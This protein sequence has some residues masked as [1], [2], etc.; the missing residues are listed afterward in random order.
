[1][2]RIDEHLDATRSPRDFDP[3]CPPAGY[4]MPFALLSGEHDPHCG[5]PQ[6]EFFAYHRKNSGKPNCNKNFYKA[7]RR[8]ANQRSQAF[9]AQLSS[10]P[11]LR[12]AERLFLRAMTEFD[13]L[14]RGGPPYRA[15]LVERLF[16][17][18]NK[19][20]KVRTS[21]EARSAAVDAFYTLQETKKRHIL[22]LRKH[23]YEGDFEG[24][25]I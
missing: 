11:N 21:A 8:A 24:G 18:L 6:P 5:V 17:R 1:M 23:G 7:A 20:S 16:D 10:W 19:K 12:E 15:G 2:S 4:K 13:H 14:S 9:G 22:L 25:P 3:S